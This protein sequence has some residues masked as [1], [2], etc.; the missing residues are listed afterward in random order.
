MNSC[1]I[2]I[3]SNMDADLNIPGSLKIIAQDLKIIQVSKMVKTKPVGFTD[4]ADFTNGAIKIETDWTQQKLSKYLKKVED[5]MGRE[6]SSGKFSPRN[7]DLDMLIWND[8]VIDPDYYTREF[9]RQSAAELGFFRKD[10]L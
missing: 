2:G 4:Q 1:I 3:G 10:D 8:Q 6:R 7:I 9:L 5:Q